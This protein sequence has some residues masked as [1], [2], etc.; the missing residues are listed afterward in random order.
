MEQGAITRNENG[1]YTI[2]PDKVQAASDSLAR[3]IITIQGDGDYDKAGEI[4]DKY[5]IMT[6]DLKADLQRL[7]DAN[8]PVDVTWKQGKDVLGL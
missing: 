2:N 6:D 8:I 4:M 3:L 7:E 5:M 1:T